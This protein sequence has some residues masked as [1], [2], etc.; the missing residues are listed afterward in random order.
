[1]RTTVDIQDALLK[2]A[3]ELAAGQGKRLADVVNDALSEKL[4]REAQVGAGRQGEPYR[5]RPVA[6]R[7]A[8]GID[9]D[10]NASLQEATDDAAREPGAGS[11]EL[12]R[13]R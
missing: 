7:A 4:A 10:S 1:M 12:D 5:I 2:R 3:K 8:A 6:G 13:L 9:L 11:L